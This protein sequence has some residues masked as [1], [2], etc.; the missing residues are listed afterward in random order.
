M[1]RKNNQGYQK[2]HQNIKDCFGRL[3]ERKNFRLI[4]IQ[5]ICLEAGINRSTFYAHYQDI[6][7]VLDQIGQDLAQDLLTDYEKA[8]SLRK[9]TGQDYAMIF[10]AHCQKHRRY[11]RV[12]L[13]D[14]SN[15]VLANDFTLLQQHI[16]APLLKYYQVDERAGSYYFNF[17]KAGFMAVLKQWLDDGCPETTEKMAKILMNLRPVD[18]HLI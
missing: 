3:I 7:D 1:N 15:P 10:F 18:D 8:R 2:T 12:L 16:A 11:Y 4:T 17:M 9:L 5:E 6:Y 14:P 13:T